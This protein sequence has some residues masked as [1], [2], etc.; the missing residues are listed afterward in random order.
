MV[1]YTYAVLEDHVEDLW[2]WVTQVER[3]AG[4]SFAEFHF[5]SRAKQSFRIW[6]GTPQNRERFYQRLQIEHPWSVFDFG[7]PTGELKSSP[8][9]TKGFEIAV[10]SR[11]QPS[12]GSESYRRPSYVYLECHPDILNQGALGLAGFLELGTHIWRMV[13][14]KYGFIDIETGVPLQDNISRNA[15]HL[16]DSTVPPIYHQEYRLW[17]RLDAQLDKRIWK[18]FWGNFLGA[19]HLRQLGGIQRMRSEDPRYRLLPE[20]LEQAYKEGHY[21]IK[22]CDS[23]CELRDLSNQGILVTLSA[24]PL[25]WFEAEV[26]QRRELLQNILKPIALVNENID[27]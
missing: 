22:Q 7:W 20:Y 2:N 13:N 12:Q 9:K 8:W 5:S 18:A 14:G 26:Q 10:G 17:Q 11:P 1:I 3:W 4:H 6:K 27:K 21:Q 19:E 16:F 15:I 23:S 24:S 25:D